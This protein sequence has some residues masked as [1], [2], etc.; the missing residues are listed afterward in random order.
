MLYPKSVS[1]TYASLPPCHSSLRTPW[2]ATGSPRFCWPRGKDNA[3]ATPFQTP[4]RTLSVRQ[5]WIGLFKRKPR[6]SLGEGGAEQEHASELLLFPAKRLRSNRLLIAALQYKRN[7]FFSVL[8][9]FWGSMGSTFT[10]DVCS[11]LKSKTIRA[12]C[13]LTATTS[14]W[15]YYLT[16]TVLE[17]WENRNRMCSS[18]QWIFFFLNIWYLI[19]QCQVNIVWKPSL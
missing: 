1:T 8:F 5:Q 16:I 2:R 12:F 3:L 18:S 9:R 6:V 13:A 11:S 15:D 10:S 7:H 4:A 17:R 14:C 19:L